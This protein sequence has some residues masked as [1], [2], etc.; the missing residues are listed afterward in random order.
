MD[1]FNPIISKVAKG[2]EG[3]TILIYGSNRTGK[4]K[5]AVKF[6][7]PY[8]MPFESGLNAIAGVPFL[9]IQKWSDFK[10]LNKQLTN[11]KTLDKAKELYQT[12][13]FDGVESAS[14]M[15]QDYICSKF[16]AESIGSGNGGYGLWKEYEAEFKREL[17]LLTSVGYTIIFISHEGT[18]EFADENGEKYDKIYP[19]GDKRSIDP[20]CDLC[21]II[22]YAKVNGLD[23]NGKETNSSLLMVN[24]K[25]YHAGSRF[26]YLI[27][28]LKDFTAENLEQSICDAIT[29]QE[30]NNKNSTI[31]YKKY[32]NEI[33][34]E[35]VEKTYEEIKEEIKEYVLKL[36]DAGRMEE[37]TAIVEEYL[38]KDGSVKE[39]KKS[40]TQ[41]LEL[42]LDDLKNLDI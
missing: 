2:L 22:A 23:E 24:T 3:K 35:K 20:I 40:Q 34:A 11:S 6:K 4:T 17:N 39:A 21:D 38:G 42:I 8:Y 30:K 37:Y 28:Y 14:L 25:K 19:K 5:N 9:P 13:I 41:Q 26:D 1:I 31:D 33:E 27:P 12:L 36:K 18:R 32:I 10:K 29:E 7:K 15:C 16:E